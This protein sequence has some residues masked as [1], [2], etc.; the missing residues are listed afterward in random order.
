MRKTND[1]KLRKIIKDLHPVELAMLTE[2]IETM[3]N[4]T[5]KD[6]EENP[7]SYNNF[8]VSHENYKDMAEKVLT[9][10]ENN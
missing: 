4:L 2:R 7:E 8:F 5:I 3:M 6:V 9:I 1:Q 10:L